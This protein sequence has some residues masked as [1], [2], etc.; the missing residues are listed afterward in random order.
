M[1][2]WGLKTSDFLDTNI[3]TFHHKHRN[4]VPKKSD[5]FHF[6]AGNGAKF[7]VFRILQYLESGQ[8]VVASEAILSPLTTAFGRPKPTEKGC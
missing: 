8:G 7:R 3:R 2:F 4:F 5:V 1:T 6:P